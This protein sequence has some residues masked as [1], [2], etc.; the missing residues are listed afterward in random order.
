MAVLKSCRHLD[1]WSQVLHKVDV[2]ETLKF[3]G[4]NAQKKNRMFNVTFH[5]LPPERYQQDKMLTPQQIL[6]YM[7]NRYW[8]LILTIV[9]SGGHHSFSDIH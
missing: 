3:E 4:K 5:F 8:C 2:V 6:H 9:G 1:A 7:E